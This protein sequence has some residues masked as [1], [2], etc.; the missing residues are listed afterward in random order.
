M[1]IRLNRRF[2]AE[3]KHFWKS[4]GTRRAKAAKCGEKATDIKEK[5]AGDVVEMIISGADACVPVSFYGSRFVV[6]RREQ[7][8]LRNYH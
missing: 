1:F 2:I 7:N 3:V 5:V 4:V 8:E 6:H